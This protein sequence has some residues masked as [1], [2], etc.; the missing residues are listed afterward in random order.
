MASS[1]APAT[2]TVTT[3][4]S[5]APA[6]AAPAAAMTAPSPRALL[7]LGVVYAVAINGTIL[8]PFIVS[9]LM[10]RFGLD[11]GQATMM[12]GFEMLGMA[13]SC[14]LLPH[15]AARFALR[16]AWIGTLGAITCQVASALLAGAQ[17]VGIARGLAGVFEG[18]LFM[19]VAAR[20]ANQPS[21]ERIWGAIILFAGL[22][23]GALLIGISYLPERWAAQWLFL[24]LAALI[25]IAA[26]LLLHA[27]RD[28]V[29]A[30]R[31]AASAAGL[32]WLRV[33]AVW[34]F[35]ILIYGVQAGQWAVTELV[36]QHAG[37]ATSTIGI[38]L[39]LS[40]FLGFVG[41]IASSWRGSH[42]HRMPIICA[43]QLLMI[44]SLLWFFSTR[45]GAA[46]FSSQ[47]LLNVGFYALTP[48][49]TGLL[50][51]IDEDGSLVSR[52]VVVTLVGVAFGTTL[53]GWL[54]TALGVEHFGMVLAAA[55]L[56]GV[57]LV[58]IAFS[59]PGTART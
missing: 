6:S 51:E 4:D 17:A 46:Y 24:A 13:L 14:M 3:L 56:L 20:V 59:R 9:T 28:I 37:L 7:R 11:E 12:T 1:A 47:F 32:P 44:V 29:H 33:G 48:F 25:A 26:P 27:G 8:T 35:T 41:C 5:T 15:L 39:S 16:F 36:G 55:V 19:L 40:S 45:N 22:V 57:P 18:M 49:L 54:L 34:L 42:R 52:T 21:A 50:S 30:P 10:L 38:L 43:A 58:A 31:Q 23:N 53:A 2:A